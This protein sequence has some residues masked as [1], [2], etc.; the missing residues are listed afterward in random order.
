MVAA[1]IIDRSGGVGIQ[2][3]LTQILRGLMQQLLDNRLG[4]RSNKLLLFGREARSVQT[5]TQF[6]S[7][8]YLGPPLSSIGRQHSNGLRA[9][10]QGFRTFDPQVIDP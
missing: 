7:Q 5:D 4:H 10:G 8:K 9:L 2:S 1:D 3:N 6:F